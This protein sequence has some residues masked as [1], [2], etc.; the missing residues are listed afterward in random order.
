MTARDRKVADIEDAK[1]RDAADPAVAARREATEATEAKEAKEAKVEE[2]ERLEAGGVVP[3]LARRIVAA[4]LQSF[5][6]TEEVL[7]KAVG[8]TLPQDWIDFA[9]DQ[10]SRT[11]AEFLDRL[12]REIGRVL[13]RTDPAEMLAKLLEGR[14]VEVRAT[15]RLRPSEDGSPGFELKTEPRK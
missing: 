12:T 11:Q 14:E 3:E 6:S 4:G 5:F 9:S 15:F 8:D 2:H 7:R 13:D 10:S 1:S